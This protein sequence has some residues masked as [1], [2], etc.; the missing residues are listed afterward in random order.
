MP[1]LRKPDGCQH[2]TFH[3]KIAAKLDEPSGFNLNA[4]ANPTASP[5]REEN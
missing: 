4:A 5:E 1:L 3:V 2:L